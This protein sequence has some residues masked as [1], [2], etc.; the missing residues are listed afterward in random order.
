ME[1][2]NYLGKNIS[3]CHFAHTKNPTRTAL[4]V[5][6]T[7]ALQGERLTVSAMAWPTLIIHKEIIFHWIYIHKEKGHVKLN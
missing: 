4:A 3:Q 5:H 2:L 6:I 1:K 7:S